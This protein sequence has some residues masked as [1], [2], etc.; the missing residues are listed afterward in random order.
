[1]NMGKKIEDI[2][3]MQRKWWAEYMQATSTTKQ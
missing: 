1:M 2:Y 3:R